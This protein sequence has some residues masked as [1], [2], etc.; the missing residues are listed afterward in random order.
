M[1]LRIHLGFALALAGSGAP[2]LAAR[3]SAPD[4]VARAA[5][6]PASV[7][8]DGAAA[9]VL[10][11]DALLDVGRDGTFTT[12]TRYIVQILTLE[13]RRHAQAFVPYSTGA[14]KVQSVRAWL[15]RRSGAV[16]VYGKKEM[17]DIALHTNALE[18]YAESRAQVIRPEINTIAVG[19]VF[20]FESVIQERSIFAQRLWHFQGKLPVERSSFMLTL[21]PGWE[22]ETRT[23]NH[24]A[25]EP[26]GDGAARTWALERLPA[27]ETEPFSPPA[28]AYIPALAIDLRPPPSEAARLRLLGNMSWE[29]LSVYFT[30]HYDAA[31][32]PDA[33][34][35][36]RAQALTT[37]HDSSWERTKALAR[38]AQ[39]VNYIS[40]VIDAGRAGG[41][42]PRPARDVFRLNYGDCKD[43]AT[44]LRSLLATQGI[45]A[46]PA[47]VFA[48]DEAHVREEWP[49]PHQFNHCILAIEVDDDIDTPAAVTHPALGRLVY[50]DPTDELTPPGLLRSGSLASKALLLAGERGGLVTLPTGDSANDRLERVIRARID[51]AGHVT[52]TIEE[53]FQGLTSSAVRAE[54]RARSTTDYH[55]LIERWLARTLPTPTASRVEAVEDAAAPCF[56]LAIDFAAPGYGKPM[57]DVLLMFKPVLVARREH[58]VLTRTDRRLPLK[59]AP[60]SFRET[61][62]IALPEGFRVDELPPP[63]DLQTTFGT[64]RARARVEDHHLHIERSLEVMRSTVPAAE[65]KTV[66]AFFESILRAEQ[67]PVVLQRL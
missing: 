12:R 13:G 59:I 61:S 40:I 14:D 58:P 15:K 7:P 53:V 11:D 43:K 4:W 32:E 50:F 3:D 21:P 44:L 60:Q 62:L 35:R 46:H 26:S 36:A 42:I 67:T 37:G 2:L 31:S 49:S 33:A 63:V 19:D 56:S 20:A 5:A 51:G 39:Q 9:V 24:P 54:R 57:R 1:T 17:A 23:F 6:T 66:K 65:A 10:L 22:V 47:I 18:L 8:V 55:K 29:A 16:T 30:K 25:L 64:Y 34:L 28:S 45:T 38:F 27:P 52:G 48:G 41:M